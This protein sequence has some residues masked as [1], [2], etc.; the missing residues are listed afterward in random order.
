LPNRGELYIEE[1]LQKYI[2]Q[3]VSDELED[4]N[5]K[6]S[7]IEQQIKKNLNLKIP[8]FLL[9]HKLKFLFNKKLL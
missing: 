6:L 4:I 1:L 3:S 8:F 5:I 9:K 2:K 7:S